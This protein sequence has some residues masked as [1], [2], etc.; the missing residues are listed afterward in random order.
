LR[1]GSPAI[2]S[3]FDSDPTIQYD[4]AGLDRRQG[5]SVDIGAYEYIWEENPRIDGNES[6]LNET[7]DSSDN[8]SSTSGN[9]KEVNQEDSGNQESNSTSDSV[10]TASG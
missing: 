2:D 3:G 5:S 8:N 7:T 9:S 6:T 4:I 10:S 1:P